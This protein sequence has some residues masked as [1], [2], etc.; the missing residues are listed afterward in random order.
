MLNYK[1][2]CLYHCPMLC[3]HSWIICYSLPCQTQHDINGHLFQ[4][5]CN[6]CFA[7]CS[8]LITTR[9]IVPFHFKTCKHLDDCFLGVFLIWYIKIHHIYT[10]SSVT[11]NS[12]IHKNLYILLLLKLLGNSYTR[13][14]LFFEISHCTTW[15]ACWYAH[16]IQSFPL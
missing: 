10:L 5:S 12:Y 16:S 8:F 15:N 14:I 2:N 13:L 6:I 9:I 1:L 4:S 3:S 11:S 7:M